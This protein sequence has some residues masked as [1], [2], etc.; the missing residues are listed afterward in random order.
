M[1]RHALI[2]EKIKTYEWMCLSD[3]A[4]A[5]MGG[6]DFSENPIP[7]WEE[8]QEAF[9]DFYYM[10]SGKESGSVMIIANEHE[11]VGCTCYACF[12]LYSKMAEL[13]IWLKSESAC[14]KGIGTQALK[15]TI[16]YLN[17]ELG[18]NKFLIRPS[19][20]NIRAIKSYQKAG[21][22]YRTDKEDILRKFYKPI[23]FGIYKGGDY[24]FENTAVLILEL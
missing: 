22:I 11:E 6:T 17:K 9:E 16:N 23:S 13:D 14:G 5:H 4:T 24:G 18:I 21:F 19:E 20:K 8:F 1:I 12:H 2:N 7:T 3:T 10:E 15:D